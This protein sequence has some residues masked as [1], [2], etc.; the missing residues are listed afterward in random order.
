[1]EDDEAQRRVFQKHFSRSKKIKLLL[2]S[3]GFEGLVCLGKAKPNLL[4]SDLKMPGMDGFQMI[5]VLKK[6]KTF[7]DLNI[8]VLTSM[9]SDEIAEH[10][11][12]PSDIKIF[13]KPG[14]LKKLDGF[15]DQLILANNR[16]N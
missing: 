4:I 9:T 13:T 1:M 11:G 8:T 6:N 2:A 7:S 5:Q 14:P 3:N 16:N 12:L 10:G 15:I